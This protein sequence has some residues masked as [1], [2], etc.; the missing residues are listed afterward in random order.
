[1]SLTSQSS[2][3]EFLDRKYIE[4]NN[5]LYYID[6][7]SEIHFVN[8]GLYIL[9]QW[10]YKVNILNSK[11]IEIGSNS[12]YIIYVCSQEICKRRMEC[13]NDELNEYIFGGLTHSE[14][15]CDPINQRVT[16]IDKVGYFKTYILK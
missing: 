11:F 16:K 9:D 6:S 3:I 1:M 15:Q 7:K 12:K 4:S 5:R 8:Q 14:Y 13:E 10:N 2:E